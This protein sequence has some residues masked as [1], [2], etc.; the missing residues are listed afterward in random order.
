MQTTGVLPHA[1]VHV[2]EPPPDRSYLGFEVVDPNDALTLQPFPWTDLCSTVAE[3]LSSRSLRPS[4]SDSPLVNTTT[5]PPWPERASHAR[6]CMLGAILPRYQTH[7][8]ITLCYRGARTM[9]ARKH[10][11][12]VRLNAHC[13]CIFMKAW[14]DST[15]LT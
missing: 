1:L 9:Q 14:L 2:Q 3:A 4:R 6:L 8:L 13:T 10:W 5:R 11:H 7:V 12:D 15:V